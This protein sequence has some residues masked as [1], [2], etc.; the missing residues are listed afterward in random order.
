M[1]P[2]L[3]DYKGPLGLLAGLGYLPV[4][5]AQAAAQRKQGVYVLRLKGFVEP[6]LSEFPG[7]IIGLGE[8]GGMIKAFRAAGCQTVCFAGKVSRPDFSCL[9]PDLKGMS[10]LPK[11]VSAARKGDDALLRVIVEAFEAEGFD[12]IGADTASGKLIASEGLI[13]GPVPEDEQMSDLRKAARIAS[14]VGRLDIGQGAIVC[15]GLVLCVEAQEGTDAMLRRCSE[16]DERLRGSVQNRR[17]VL[18]KRPKPIQERRIDLPT[19]GL[20]TIERVAEAGLA[21][22][23]IEAGGALLVDR[24]AVMERASDLGIFIFGFP[25]EWA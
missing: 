15:D 19:I 20:A 24:Q 16:L 6:A 17:G 1:P 12:V 4:Q 3:G 21:G 25:R 23:G 5:V 10:L 14:E 11:V 2:A 13:S 18:V 22:I 9:K 7:E 8:V